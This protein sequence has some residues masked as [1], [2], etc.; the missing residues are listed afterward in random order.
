MNTTLSCETCPKRCT[1]A[2]M[3]GQEWLCL[4]GVVFVLFVG[5]KGLHLRHMEVPRLG[6]KLELQL[7]AYTTATAAQD[8]SRICHLYHSSGQCWILNPLS[9]ARDPT[10]IT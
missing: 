5:F 1:H 4:L 2:I 8:P 7:P 9:E 10:H 6:V 3:H